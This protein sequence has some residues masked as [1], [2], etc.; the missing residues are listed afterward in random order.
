M[1]I[2]NSFSEGEVKTLE[3]ILQTL[4]R[5]G[6]PSVATRQRDFASVY[7]KVL[8]MKE[9]IGVHEKKAELQEV[10]DKSSTGS[11]L[12]T[13]G[14]NQNLSSS[15]SLNEEAQ[16]NEASGAFESKDEALLSDSSIA[17]GLAAR[18][19]GAVLNAPR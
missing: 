14:L 6:N 10:Q 12:G 2:S 8:K 11:E 16:M 18:H 7:R 5:G 1:R 4:L 9:R 13:D 15:P 3:F 17:S 19:Q